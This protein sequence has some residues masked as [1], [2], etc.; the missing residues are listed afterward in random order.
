MPRRGGGRRGCGDAAVAG[1]GGQRRAA[2]ERFRT[3]PRPGVGVLVVEVVADFVERLP[4]P[5]N[6]NCPCKAKARLKGAVERWVGVGRG[7]RRTHE[8]RWI[9]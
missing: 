4:V 5:A 3:R 2:G 8:K 6:V 1:V 9:Q 7:P